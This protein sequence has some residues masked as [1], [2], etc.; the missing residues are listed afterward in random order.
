MYYE[1]YIDVLFLSNFLM[2]YLLLL[3]IWRVLACSATHVRILLGAAAGAF[4]ACVAVMLPFPFPMLKLA[5]F[6]VVIGTVMI[7]TA[8]QISEKTLF[9]EIF[10]MLYISSFLMGGILNYLETVLDSWTQKSMAGP[11][12]TVFL[13]LA[14]IV[15]YYLMRGIGFFVKRMQRNLKSKCRVVLY[16]S[17]GTY[18]L[19]ALLDTGNELVDTVSGK[20]VSIIEKSL[21]E[22]I[23][24]EEEMNTMRYVPYHSI[25]KTGVLPTVRITSMV[26][27]QQRREFRIEGPMIGI[28][29]R[30]ISTRKSYQIILNPDILGGTLSC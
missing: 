26:V 1:V 13:L 10:G 27:K 21:A 11:W 22:Q 29:E 20:G 16:T 19:Q 30:S 7:K 28:S 2:D 18:E 6:H 8:Y 14:V 24:L 12:N 15:S 23:F 9:W 3:F 4:M 25:G 17:A 5:L